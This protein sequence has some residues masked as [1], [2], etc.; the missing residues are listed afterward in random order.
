MEALLFPAVEAFQE[1]LSSDPLGVAVSSPV[2]AISQA[3][4][5]TGQ[6]STFVAVG[7]AEEDAA[8]IADNLM[9]S[10]VA[11]FILT[12]FSCPLRLYEALQQ[13]RHRRK[14]RLP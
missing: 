6:G 1:D 5:S 12:N 11:Y 10:V 13:A 8:Q 14:L 4:V 7:F 9:D 2:M 3:F